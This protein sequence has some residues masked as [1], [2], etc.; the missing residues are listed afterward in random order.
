MADLLVSIPSRSRP[1]QLDRTLKMLADTCVSLENFDVQVIIDKD[2]KDYYIPDIP[3]GMNVRFFYPDYAGG[4]WG[5]IYTI[6][7]GS[8]LD[9]KW[10]FQW[11]PPDDMYG[12]SEKW[13]TAI[14]DKRGLF[15]GLYM[16]YTDGAKNWGRTL[17]AH[18][19]CY[20]GIRTHPSFPQDLV[21][22]HEPNPIW[23]RE[24]LAKCSSLF[25][26]GTKYVVFR[27]LIFA[28]I[29]RL[30]AIEHNEY[31]NAHCDIKYTYIVNDLNSVKYAQ[32]WFDLQKREYDELRPVAQLMKAYIDSKK[33]SK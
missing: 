27:E 15:D 5:N 13:D 7:H 2:Q 21:D 23:T 24:W 11:C 28:A 12:L 32:A 19:T 14:L 9:G 8:F 1:Q 20:T 22:S 25:L 29:L 30:L 26:P 10:Y 16:L 18:S 3:K 6:Q 31:R 17:E 4:H 33:E